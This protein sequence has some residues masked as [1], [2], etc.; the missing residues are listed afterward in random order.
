MFVSCS[1]CGFG[2]HVSGTILVSI[3]SAALGDEVGCTLEERVEPGTIED[4]TD[5]RS[6]PLS[7]FTT[8]EWPGRRLL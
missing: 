6:A 3:C 8:V 7:L 5:V 1:S 2:G 4:A